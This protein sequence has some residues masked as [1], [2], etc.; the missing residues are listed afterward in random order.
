MDGYTGSVNDNH[1]RAAR[2]AIFVVLAASL[3]ASAVEVAV[4]QIEPGLGLPPVSAAGASIQ[5]GYAPA[6]FT[7][8]TL[9]PSFMPS[10]PLAAP[11]AMAAPVAAPVAAPSAAVLPGLPAAAAPASAVRAVSAAEAP[12][13]PAG[14]P[15]LDSLN[16][17][18]ASRHH[19]GKV[20]DG[21]R[22]QKPASTG[23]VVNDEGVRVNDR[24][25][26]YYQEVRRMV[27]Q[28]KG[29]VD[30]SESLDVMDDAYG[31]VL[32]KVSAV[33][34]VAK[35]RGL[36]QENTHL[37]QT[38]TWV[39]GVLTDGKKTIAVHTH[40]VFFHHAKNPQSEIEEGIRR[41]DGY[42]A[43]AERM[44]ARGGKAEQ[45]LGPLDEVE[46]VFDS[47]GYQAIKDHLKTRA[48]E[49]EARS[50]GRITFKYLD[51]LAP[52]PQD[53]AVIRERLNG[54]TK[55]YSG[56]GLEKI[57]EG[58]IYSRYVGLLLE[59][60]TVEHYHNLGYKILQSGRELFDENGKYVSE[61][62]VVVQS[63]EGKVLLVEAKSARVGLP[64]EEVLKDKVLYKLDTYKKHKAELDGMI[65]R[66][67][68]EVVFSM[69]IAINPDAAGDPRRLTY[70]DTQ[71]LALAE[72]LRKQEPMLSAKYGFPVRFL[73]LQSGP[74]DASR[75]AGNTA[76]RGGRR[77]GRRR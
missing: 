3:P 5:T 65:G 38:L 8:P 71:K 67:F 45:Q 50:H 16:A 46:L 54:L 40:R 66:P 58:V 42:I 43:D 2:L 1:R 77:H 11:S 68:D 70:R 51:D 17:A 34:A 19:G 72:Y 33:E 76:E 62:D 49:V 20:F 28:Y 15:A 22:A 7:V 52:M 61:L 56:Q 32:A 44:F 14:A 35:G 4:P 25:A 13:A 31:D 9:A 12:A 47:R 74:G 37:E 73:F 30:L 24:A 21:G 41:V 64:F 23:Y 63:P 59:L 75:P 48:A 57:I 27:E 10:A 18:A 36:S 29:Q 55:K 6:A 60:K 39:D 26:E 53:Q 69:D